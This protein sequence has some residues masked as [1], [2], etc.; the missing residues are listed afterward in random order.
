WEV[1]EP[2][3]DLPDHVRGLEA[4]ISGV[5]ARDK[6]GGPVLLLERRHWVGLLGVKLEQLPAGDEEIEPWA[7]GE[8][9]LELGCRPHDLLEVVEEK[10]KPLL[11][12]VVRGAV[13][14]SDRLSGLLEHEG[15]IAP[16]G[17]RPQV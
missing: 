2:A 5:G 3:A 9:V 7:R 12:D 1:V 15:G 6:E 4:G 16:R 17:K 14:R 11:F 8:Q 13:L 10:Q